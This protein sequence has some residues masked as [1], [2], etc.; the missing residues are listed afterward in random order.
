LFFSSGRRS[1]HLFE[2]PVSLLEEMAGHYSLVAGCLALFDH[3]GLGSR[4]P[5]LLWGEPALPTS[6]H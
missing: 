2:E 3:V 4:S 5:L 6:E 1:A